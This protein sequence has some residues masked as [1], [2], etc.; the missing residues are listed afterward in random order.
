MLVFHSHVRLLVLIE[1]TRF[2]FDGMQSCEIMWDK[3]SDL[4]YL[5]GILWGI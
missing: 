2:F 4:I 1:V 3:E 5:V